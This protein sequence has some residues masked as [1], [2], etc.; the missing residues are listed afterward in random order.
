MPRLLH[1]PGVPASI[2][3][4]LDSLRADTK[5]LWGK[6]SVDQMLWHINVSMRE[7]TGDYTPQLKALPVPKALMRWAV[8]NIPWGKGAPTRPDM[9]VTSTHDFQ[10]Q[11]REALALLDRILARPLSAEWPTSASLGKMSGKHWSHLTAKH[12]EHHLT[13]FGV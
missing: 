12:L 3:T 8:L 4:R 7:A 11:K 9:L 1:D 2:R 10:A 13:Q 5:P 6:M